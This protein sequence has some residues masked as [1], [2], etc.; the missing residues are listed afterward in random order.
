MNLPQFGHTSINPYRSS[1]GWGFI[2]AFKIVLFHKSKKPQTMKTLTT[3]ILVG[4]AL[5]MGTTNVFSQPPNDLIANAIDL[6][7]EA[8]PYQA[9]VMFSNATNTNDH[10]PAAGCGV[11]QP[12]VWYK[13]TATKNGNIGAGITVPSDAEVIFYEGPATGVTSGTQLTFV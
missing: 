9:N 6:A 13:F 4:I 12:G 7:M 8:V 11:S 1:F 5:C 3:K 10:T 2:A